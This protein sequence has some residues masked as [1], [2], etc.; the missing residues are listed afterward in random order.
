[1]SSASKISKVSQP[2]S[3]AVSA[4]LAKMVTFSDPL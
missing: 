3:F 1:V 4:M 2:R